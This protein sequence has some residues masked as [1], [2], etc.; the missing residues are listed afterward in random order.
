MAPLGSPLQRDEALFNRAIF[1]FGSWDEAI[2][3]AGLAPQRLIPA[4][5]YTRPET[6]LAEIRRR[7]QEGMPL[8]AL[9]VT[10][11]LK[12]HRDKA[13]YRHGS[14][15]FGSWNHAIAQAGLPPQAKRFLARRYPTSEAIIQ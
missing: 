5:R 13:L 11:G 2:R 3:Q 9:A 1:L 7:H 4:A 14:R 6:I 10:A 12:E 15:W 8:N